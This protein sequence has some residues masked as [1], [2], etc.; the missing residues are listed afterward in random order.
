MLPTVS[1]VVT[2]YGNVILSLILDNFLVQFRLYQ[3]VLFFCATFFQHLPNNP[4]FVENELARVLFLM[5]CRFPWKSTLHWTQVCQ[6]TFQKLVFSRAALKIV[7]N[8]V[9][10]IGFLRTS[11]KYSNDYLPQNTT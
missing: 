6:S 7:E 11:A 9:S 4:F 10:K 1:D 3:L 8:A 5:R 2:F